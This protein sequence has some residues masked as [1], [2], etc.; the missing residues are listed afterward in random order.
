MFSSDF[1]ATNPRSKDAAMNFYRK[2]HDNSC[3]S[4]VSPQSGAQIKVINAKELRSDVTRKEYFY[5]DLL[6][7]DFSR[8][9]LTEFPTCH[10]ETTLP[11]AIFTKDAVTG[12][13]LDAI[14]HIFTELA[15][16]FGHGGKI[17]DV[18]EMFNEFK[19]G[20]KN[21]LFHD[22]AKGF[23]TEDNSLPHVDEETYNQIHCKTE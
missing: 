16:K 9:A 15:T 22:Y 19:P 11:T 3:A 10:F 14:I 4:P 1:D 8:Q 5:Y 21:V 18:F 2:L 7:T 23:V 6:C 13:Q 20:Q 17:E 12:S